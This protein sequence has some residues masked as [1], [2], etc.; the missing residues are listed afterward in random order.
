M[1]HD[2][3]KPYRVRRKE[4]CMHSSRG[5]S[6][7]DV[8]VGTAL[9]LLVFV[10]LVGVLR[11]SIAV[12]TES[13]AR[14]GALALVQEQLEYMHSLSYEHV[15]TISGLPLGSVPQEEDVVLNGITYQRRTL[16]LYVDSDKDGVGVSDGNGITT[17]YKVVKVEVSWKLA[18]GEKRIAATTNIMPPGLESNVGGGTLIVHVFDALLAPVQGADVHIVNTTG[19][20]TIDMTIA[21]SDEGKVMSPGFPAGSEYEITVTK[22][23]YTTVQ[24]YAATGA[25]PSPSPGHQVVIEGNT[26]E[27]SFQIDELAHMIVRTW[28]PIAEDMKFDDMSTTNDMQFFS[29]VSVSGGMIHLTDSGVGYYT[30]GSVTG[31]DVDP[32]YIAGWKEFSWVDTEPPG[33][34]LVYHIYDADTD[35][36]ISDEVL[37]GNSTGFTVSP[38]SLVGVSHE[39]HDSLY[40]QGV[41]E[42]TSTSTTPFLDEWT[43]V[44]DEGPIPVSDVPFRLWGT[45]TIGTDGTGDDV[46][47]YDQT[48]ATD[49]TGEVV[50]SDITWDTYD[51]LI[52][53]IYAAESFCA[54]RPHSVEPGE[55]LEIDTY[56]TLS[57]P[58]SLLVSLYATDGSP[59]TGVDMTLSRAGFSETV[60]TDD[61][62]NA[63]F[64]DLSNISDYTISVNDPVYGA[65]T[66]VDVEIS[67]QSF[68]TTMIE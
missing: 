40:V 30:S 3:L 66:V 50:I 65:V 20:S 26:T 56:L 18:S 46:F 16:V 59:A 42:T 43:L 35:T 68:L 44:Y 11:T 49:T 61:C 58:H 24:T 14:I 48:H 52:E 41:F 15:G 62:G 2:F 27:I 10:S 21:S 36:L 57:S 47:L 8:L 33:T 32:E 67:G 28:F 64:G 45:K 6:F 51:I 63:Y 5:F 54:P 53:G 25:L 12:I 19:T 55:T 39:T 37:P 22:D 13:K 9:M 17:D 31:D 4:G 34:S 38:V 7:L 60:V 29:H 23:G 1:S